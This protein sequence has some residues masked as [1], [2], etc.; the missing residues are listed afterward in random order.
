[1]KCHFLPNKMSVI[2][3]EPKQCNPVFPPAAE[4]FLYGRGRVEFTWN[5]VRKVPF[6]FLYYNSEPG[7]RLN[8]SGREIR[9]EGNE[10]I[11]IPPYTPF[12]TFCEAPFDHLYIHFNA[13]R[14]YSQVKPGVMVFDRS[15]C[16]TLDLLLNSET[17]S[18]AAVYAL[19]FSV[20]AAIPKSRFAGDDSPTDDRILR[21]MSLLSQG[22]SN[23]VICRKIG[24]SSGNFQRCFKQ[25]TGV[26]PFRYAMQLRMEKAGTLLTTTRE[27]IPSIARACGF[28]D[29]YTFS[30]SFKKQFGVPPAQYRS[31]KQKS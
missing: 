16:G 9:P 8:F 11:L 31:R 5:F 26:T 29:R 22:L 25:E 1:M 3:K 2:T 19:L 7:A 21:S 28:P 18:A 12:S 6:W 20:L 27:D 14:P 4:V 15:I 24:M 23:S 10:I 17:F 13:E 30:K